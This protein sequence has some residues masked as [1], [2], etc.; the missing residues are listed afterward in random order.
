MSPNTLLAILVVL[1]VL[2]LFSCMIVGDVFISKIAF[3]TSS[4]ECESFADLPSETTLAPTVAVSTIASSISEPTIASATVANATSTPSATT[5]ATAIPSVLNSHCAN[6]DTVQLGF[7]KFRIIIFWI[8]FIILTGVAG[9]YAKSLIIGPIGIAITALGFIFWVF[10]F[11]GTIFLS[12]FIFQSSE[13]SCN[14]KSY[15]CYD[16]NDAKIFFSRITSIIS[17]M[18]TF[19]IT[20]F[21]VFTLYKTI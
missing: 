12:Q 9:F 2:A 3:N 7:A 8:M 10:L 17:F 20:F 1:G 15:Y 5:T 21:I 13:K 14:N 6:L 16:F 11:V 19:I 18:S 4:E